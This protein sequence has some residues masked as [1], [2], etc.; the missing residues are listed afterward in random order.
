VKEFC[1]ANESYFRRSVVEYN[2]DY[3]VRNTLGHVLELKRGANPAAQV[4]NMNTISEMY[5]DLQEGRSPLMLYPWHVVMVTGLTITQNFVP[6]R[7][8]YQV[9][10]YEVTIEYYDPNHMGVTQTRQ[11]IVDKDFKRTVGADPIFVVNPEDGVSP[12]AC[13][14]KRRENERWSP[15]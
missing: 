12:D 15:Y 10:H 2:A 8:D 11:L 9:D 3:T 7:S 14:R 4:E 5:T 6:N 1:A 13:D